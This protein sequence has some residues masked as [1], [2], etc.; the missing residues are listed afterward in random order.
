M[1]PSTELSGKRKAAIT[2]VTL[3]SEMSAEI[4]KHLDEAKIEQLTLEIAGLGNV[5]HETR[6]QVLEEFYE[7]C[8][9]QE[10]AAGGIEYVRQVLER[11]LGPHR[12]S[13]IIDKITASLQEKPFS[14]AR[15]VDPAQ[16]VN[17]IENEHP[18]T[19][20]LILAYLHPEQ[21]AVVLSALPEG[22]QTEVAVRL[23]EMDRTSPEV[24]AE[25]EKVLENRLYAI[26]GQS[27]NFAGGTKAL[28][29]VLNRVD[30]ATEKTIL[31]E[32]EE[33]NPALAEEVKNLMFVFEDITLL[34]DRAIQTFL[35]EIDTKDLALALKA[36]SDEVK[37]RIFSNM[38][39][40]AAEMLREDMEFMGPVRLRVVEEAQQRIVTVIRRLEEAGDI[41][42]ARGTEDEVLV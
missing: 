38:S 14:F 32:L 39:E 33:Q 34:D 19:I 26:G 2:L 13:E 23:A 35:K 10:F 12:A 37:K 3:G 22:L 17:F 21:S 16:L 11:A 41:V 5:P 1:A 6:R 28:V 25:V 42:I 31:E 20:A 40:R 15:Q 8:D 7:K 18:Q 29:D 27:Y 4:F 9:A 36:A 30:R 24:V